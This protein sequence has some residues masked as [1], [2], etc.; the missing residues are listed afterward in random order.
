MFWKGFLQRGHFLW[1]N[2]NPFASLSSSSGQQI[3]KDKSRIIDCEKRQR[4][5]DLNLYAL[6]E[7]RKAMARQHFDSIDMNGTDWQMEKIGDARRSAWIKCGFGLRE[8]FA[9]GSELPLSV[10]L[11]HQTKF[12]Q[13]LI[14]VINR[15]ILQRVYIYQL[16]FSSLTFFLNVCFWSDWATRGA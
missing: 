9:A 1:L 2:Q 7:S 10:I 4:K 15:W 3:F 5:E 16:L 6:G 13:L 12:C 11:Q 8:I 14:L